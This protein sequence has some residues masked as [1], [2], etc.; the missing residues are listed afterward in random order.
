MSLYKLDRI[1]YSKTK[2]EFYFFEFFKVNKGEIK[3]NTNKQLKEFLNYFKKE[4]LI[5]EAGEK[6]EILRQIIKDYDK[7]KYF[8]IIYSDDKDESKILIKYASNSKSNYEIF[9]DFNELRN[10]FIKINGVDNDINNYSKVLGELGHNQFV[11]NTLEKINDKDEKMEFDDQGLE[12][13]I[14][15]LTKV[16]DYG[17]EFKE[18]TKGF[19]LDLFQYINGKLII[20]E[21]LTNESGMATNKCHPMRYCWTGGKK[22][23]KEKFISLWKTKD[24]F[25]G[26][27]FLINH[28]KVEKDVSVLKIID[29]DEKEGIKKEL[30]LNMSYEQFKNWLKFMRDNEND[31][32]YF[33]KLDFKKKSYYDAEFFNYFN[34]KK[35]EYK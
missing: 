22:D 5:D 31:Y 13:T 11:H 14:E 4:Y 33:D 32:N 29:L 17:K 9:K 12:F 25:N 30:K 16:N 6:H 26:E 2:K 20:Y 3:I 19:D 34:D 18:T 35:K 21:F 23:N 24:F 28:S 7:T 8:F 1:Q 15:L 10:W 27:L